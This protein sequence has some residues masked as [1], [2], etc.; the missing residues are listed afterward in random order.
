[1]IKDADALL[2]KI[3]P[4]VDKVVDLI[5]HMSLSRNIN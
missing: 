2:K 3:L 4:G 1:M 5:D